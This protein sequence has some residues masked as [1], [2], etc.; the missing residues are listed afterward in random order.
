MDWR[1]VITVL[2]ILMGAYSAVAYIRTILAGESKPHRVTWGGWT[3]VGLLGL[4]SSVRGGA[5]VG[6]F[7]SASFVVGVAAIFALSCLRDY[8]KPG[9]GKLDYIA[10]VIAAAALLTQLFVDYSPNIGQT[11][12]IAADLVFLWPTIREAWFHPEYEA[13]H[14]WVLGAV[15]EVMGIA[16]LGN[17]SYAAAGYSVYIFLGNVSV[18]LVLTFTSHRKPVKRRRA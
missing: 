5:G 17:Y 16:A 3:L 12:A 2:G 10:G 1:V 6:L 13:V 9:G 15:A 4:L 8:G 11:I 7:V 18:I 14:P